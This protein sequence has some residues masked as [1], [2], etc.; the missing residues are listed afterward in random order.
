MEDRLVSHIQYTICRNATYYYNRRVPKHAEKQYG[1]F[2]RHSLGK[3][4][5]L[6]AKIAVRLTSLLE[7]SWS[8]NQH[9]VPINIVE[10]ISSYQKKS[11]T[12]LEVLN[13]YIEIKDINKKVS[14]IAAS[15]LVSLVGNKRIEDYTREDAKLL[16]SYL[17]RKGN[18]T[19]TIRRR[20]GSLSGVFNYAFAEL[21]IDKRNPFSR[22]LLVGEG[23]DSK[24]RGT[25]TP[26]QLVQGYKN[27]FDTRSN[28]KLLMPI[29]GE[30]GCR[31]GEIVGLRKEDVCLGSN[32]LNITP[33]DNR[34]LKT[35]SSAR[36][37][38]LVG[39]AH[40]ALDIVMQTSKGDFVFEQYNKDKECK[41]TAASNAVSK[42]L[43]KEFNGLTAHCLRHTF[44]D[45]LRAVECPM[46]IIDELGGWSTV[47]TAGNRY[48]LGHKFETKMKWMERI[49]LN[50]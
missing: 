34:R 6:A 12:L 40:E 18:K 24:K 5:D 20:L 27:A 11:Y 41:T 29:L 21:E 38:P 39:Y 46:E 43:K 25:F 47:S 3:C 19:T 48:G 32:T 37:I 10:T 30:T 13:D 15:T 2:L 45:R 4:P 49:K 35:K 14:H 31:L 8:N 33:N 22:I 16:V 50:I 9:I 7:S 36:V 44:R 17:G 23:L 1:K 26:E 42:W 28:I